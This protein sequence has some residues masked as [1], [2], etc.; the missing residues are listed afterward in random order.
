[1]PYFQLMDFLRQRQLGYVS[2]GCGND[3][4]WL[5][6]VLAGVRVCVCVCVC[7]AMPWCG[8]GINEL[9]QEP[10]KTTERCVLSKSMC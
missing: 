9:L 8:C 2:N 7:F 10:D 6:L 1:M 5:G 4:M 3:V